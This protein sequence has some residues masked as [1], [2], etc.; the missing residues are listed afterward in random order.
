MNGL[1]A[2]DCAPMIF[3]SMVVIVIGLLI[4]QVPVVVVGLVGFLAGIGL[5]WTLE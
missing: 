3:W 1:T 4:D 5:I 2:R